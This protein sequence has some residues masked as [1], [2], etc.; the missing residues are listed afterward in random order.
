VQRESERRGWRARG[1]RTITACR[2][3]RR[4]RKKRSQ[5]TDP[6]DA[7]LPWRSFASAVRSRRK[8]QA[9]FLR[10][11]QPGRQGLGGMDRLAT[12]RR[13]L[14]H[15][16]PGVGLSRRRQFR[17]RHASRRRQ[18]TPDNRRPVQGLSRGAVPPG[19]M[20]GCLR[21]GPH[22]CGSSPR[23]G[24]GGRLPTGRPAAHDHLRRSGRTRRADSQAGAAHAHPWRAAQTVSP[25]RLP[26]HHRQCSDCFSP[27]RLRASR[28]HLASYAQRCSPDKPFPNLASKRS[29]KSSATRRA[30]SKTTAWRE[31]PNGRR[32]AT[33]STSASRG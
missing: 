5:V 13:R 2:A 7:T 18:R 21:A 12:R 10:Q 24:A 22:R 11:L 3:G 1:L 6:A 4:R 19:G 30:R 14:Y 25:A 29:S 33:R 17:P 32:R 8:H 23:A 9:R 15:V 20:G 26:R 27:T 31:S 16:Y 28:T